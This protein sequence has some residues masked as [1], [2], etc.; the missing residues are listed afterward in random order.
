MVSHPYTLQAFRERRIELPEA[1]TSG[2]P[3]NYMGPFK[4]TL[5]HR[6]GEGDI[7]RL[8]GNNNPKRVG[9]RVAGVVS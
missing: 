4:I 7:Y 6:T 9:R 3:L 2:H 5:S 8:H 1:G